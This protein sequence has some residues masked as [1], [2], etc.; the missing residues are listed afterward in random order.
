MAVYYLLFLQITIFRTFNSSFDAEVHVPD[1]V[2][3]Y[4]LHHLTLSYWLTEKLAVSF[5]KQRNTKNGSTVKL[6]LSKTI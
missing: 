3:N 5:E 4:V 2:L 6:D 1:D